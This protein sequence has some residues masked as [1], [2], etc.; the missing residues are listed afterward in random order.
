MKKISYRYERKD[1]RGIFRE[2]L[3][4]D[5]C[6]RAVNSG[7]MKKSSLMGN[8]YHKKNKS[9]F[10]MLSG[11]A[12]FFFRNVKKRGKTTKFR[13]NVGEGVLIHPYE[14]HTIRFREKSEFLLAKSEKFDPK[15]NDLYEARLL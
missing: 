2:Y 8:N 5:Q 7:W 12:D 9:A 10:F 13:L 11:S 6:W 15:R 4:G 14:T 3:N 1:K